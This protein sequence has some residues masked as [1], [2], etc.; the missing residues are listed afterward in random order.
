MLLVVRVGSSVFVLVQG[1]PRSSGL[2]APIM[3]LTGHEVNT[4][5]HASHTHVCAHACTQA[6]V[7]THTHT[8]TL[9]FSIHCEL[10]VWRSLWLFPSL[11]VCVYVCM[12]RERFIQ[13]DSVL[14]EPLLLLPHL[15][16]KYV[17]ATSCPV[18]LSVTVHA[19][20]R[21]TSS[22]SHPRCSE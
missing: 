16:G 4:C 20:T 5:T 12:H 21:S 2:Q 19:H 6:Y 18:P 15:K 17:S 14:W 1:K 9:I 13:H 10:Y 3:Q 8:H 11:C 7:H 22:T